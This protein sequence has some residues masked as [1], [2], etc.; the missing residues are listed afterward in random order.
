MRLRPH[1]WILAWL[2]LLAATGTYVASHARLV[3]DMS[4]FLPTGASPLQTILLEQVRTGAASRLLLLAVDGAEP[5]KLAQASRELRRRAEASGLFDMVQNGAEQW[6]P[7]QQ[8]LL[9]SYRYLLND[10]VDAVYFSSAS[11]HAALQR[12][13]RILTSSMVALP[14]NDVQA[15]PTSAYLDYLLSLRPP[16][17]PEQQHD[18]W[19]SK[20]GTQALL[21][22]RTVAPAFSLEAQQQVMSFLGSVMQ[23]DPLLQPL[24]LQFS[25]PALF[26]Q[27][28]KDLIA[29]EV[30]RISLL[31]TV[32]MLAF[33]TLV[34]RNLSLVLLSALPLVSGLLAAVA[35]VTAWYGALHGIT[36]AFGATLVGVAVDY[37][38][39]L[40]AH[41]APQEAAALTMARIWPT[42]RLGLVTTVIGYFAMLFSDFTGLVQLGLFACVGLTVAVLVTRW[43]LPLL[44]P[45]SWSV[46]WRG[47]A[48][49][50][51]LRPRRALRIAL[52][53]VAGA[54]LLFILGDR[55]I[56]EEDIASLN[57]EQKAQ[58]NLDR[59]LRDQLGAPDT[60]HFILVSAASDEALLQR[61]EQLR[62]LLDALVNDG[63]IRHYEIIS[64]YLASQARQRQRQQ[65]IPAVDALA[66]NLRQGLADLP[67]RADAFAGFVTAAQASRQLPPLTLAEFRRTALGQQVDNLVFRHGDQWFGLV[68]L[69][70]IS[71][72]AALEQRLATMAAAQDV[73][74][75]DL[76]AQSNQLMSGYRDHA[77]GLA[78]IGAVGIFLALLLGLRSLPGALRVFLPTAAAALVTTLCLLL[79]GERLHLLHLASLLLVIGIGMDYSLFFQRHQDAGEE[80]AQTLRAL[81]ICAMTTILVFGILAFAVTPVLHAI[82]LTVSL[83]TLLSFLY[84]VYSAPRVAAAD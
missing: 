40:F 57:P 5:V 72:Y 44:V 16:S 81:L 32:L 62:P 76:K 31:T 11:L 42:L 10:R 7:A 54:A 71:D 21:V 45:A 47:T 38:T 69:V 80:R 82:G 36:L 23:Q 14:L 24:H 48:L 27:Q 46:R 65:A 84:A 64:R 6:T 1:P 77:L 79:L 67:F 50:P 9:F 8:P 22:A 37:P 51:L 17:S 83:G 3:T 41:K 34:F 58:K 56:W 59:H 39:H 28:A 43:L 60:R 66:A 73:V 26:A 33:L 49:D 55:Q 30:S 25:G 12:Q 20:D 75:L 18:V 35:V 61:S 63:V 52:W 68:P 19:F 53:L 15:D 70:N 4:Q 78:A 13:L 74:L 29:G 2:V